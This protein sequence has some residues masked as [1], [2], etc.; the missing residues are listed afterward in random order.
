M[1]L[2]LNITL[3]EPG[4]LFYEPLK[5]AEKA[6]SHRYRYRDR[7]RYPASGIKSR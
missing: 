1:S 4:A 5:A 7:N 6:L 3:A 2:P